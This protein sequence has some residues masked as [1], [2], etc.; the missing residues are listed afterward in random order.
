MAAPLSLAA[1]EADVARDLELTAH[2]HA[3]W[4]EPRMVAG[5]PCL[6]VLVIGAGQCGV[7]VAHASK[8]DRV[9][10]ILVVDRAGFGREGR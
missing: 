10:N 5:A 1:L 2:P 4:L 8:R 3:V 9:D 7:A 6:G